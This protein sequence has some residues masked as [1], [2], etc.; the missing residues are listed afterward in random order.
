[1]P[2]AA[3]VWLR[4]AGEWRTIA[5]GEGCCA[6]AAG[7]RVHSRGGV[8]NHGRAARRSGCSPRVR[9]R[10]A[11]A[12]PHTPHGRPQCPRSGIDVVRNKI[13]MFA[14]KKVTLPPGRHKIVILDE[15]DRWGGRG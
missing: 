14:Q 4:M 7:G 3:C 6:A 12:L 15:A 1:M 2:H 8:T 11:P 5:P 10:L 13:K 9:P